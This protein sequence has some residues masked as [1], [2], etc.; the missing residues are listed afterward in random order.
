MFRS[1]R[2]VNNLF[3]DLAREQNF[4]QKKISIGSQLQD[5]RLVAQRGVLAPSLGV[6]GASGQELDYFVFSV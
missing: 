2:S 6:G 4:L 1:L 3:G 5:E